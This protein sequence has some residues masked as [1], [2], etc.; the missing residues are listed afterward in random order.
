MN[1]TMEFSTIQEIETK[2]KI[3]WTKNYYDEDDILAVFN[4]QDDLLKKDL[5][6]KKINVRGVFHYRVTKNYKEMEK[7]YLMAIELGSAI[8]M[9]NLGVYHNNVTKN[10]EE[11]EKYYLMAIECG[12]NNAMNDL[13]VYHC[14]VTK[15]YEKMEKYYLMVIECGDNNA[16]NNLGAYHYNITKNYEK[17]EK[18]YLMAIECGN[19]NAMCNLGVYHYH[20]TKNY[21]EMEKYYL[22]AIECGNNK[23]MCNLGVY[24]Y[25]ITKN[26]KEMEKYY[27]MAIECGNN[28]TMLYLKKHYRT[29]LSL[30]RILDNHY[31]SKESHT[32]AFLTEYYR[33]IKAKIVQTHIESFISSGQSNKTNQYLYD[34]YIKNNLESTDGFITDFTIHAVILAGETKDKQDEE[35]PLNLFK[36]FHLNLSKDYHLHSLL[37]HSDFFHNLIDGEFMRSNHVTMHVSS[38]DVIDILLKYLYLGEMEHQTMTLDTVQELQDLADEYAFDSL[39]NACKNILKLKYASL[40]E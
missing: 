7:Y 8:S 20:I 4:G 31:N 28:N 25:N 23:A 13:G 11:M 18:Y 14:K 12:D 29:D 10:Y 22:M 26:Y 24:H 15:N 27:L 21:K 34:K 5:D 32:T 19:N 36:D 33:C 2:F 16:M 40:Y 38:F 35:T 6:G 17:M 9:Y 3:T 39:L 1:Q 30:F 37:L